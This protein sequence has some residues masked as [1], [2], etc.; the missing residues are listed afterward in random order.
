MNSPGADEFMAKL[1]EGVELPADHPI[2]LLRDRLIRGR[3]MG[4]RSVK[5]SS[6]DAIAYTLLAWTHVQAGT[7]V[8]SKLLLPRGE[9]LAA[10]R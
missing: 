1:D 10:S 3:I 2:L 7:S 6:S 9:P 4:S 8:L 5:L